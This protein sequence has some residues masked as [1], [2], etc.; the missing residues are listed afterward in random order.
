MLAWAATAAS[1]GA[2]MLTAAPVPATAATEAT[3][4]RTVT[5]SPFS[6][7]WSGG[8]TAPVTWNGNGAGGT[9]DVL[10]HGR[11]V[12]DYADPTVAGHGADCSPPPATHVI[13]TLADTVFICRNHI[14]TSVT[15]GGY[16]G[17]VLTPDHM[18]DF[19]SGTATVSFNVSTLHNDARDYFDIW[20]T[21]FQSNLMLPLTDAVDVAGPPQYALRV[22]DCFCGSNQDSFTGSVFNNF[23]E[24]PL[25]TVTGTALQSMLPPSAVTRTGFELDVSRNHVK[26]GVP[27][28]GLWWLD[29]AA[30]IPFTQG[31]VQLIHHSYDACKGQT[32]N[33]SNPCMADTWHWSNFSISQAVPFTIINGSPRSASAGTPTITFGAPAP[34]GAFL[35]FEALTGGLS[36]SFDG[37]HTFTAPNRQ[38][39]IGDH[40]V[41]HTEHFLPYFTPIPAGTQS[42][43]FTGQNWYAGVWWVRDISIW[44]ASGLS[45]IIT[46]PAAP[47]ANPPTNPA[48]NPPTNH[49]V[50]SPPGTKPGTSGSGSGEGTGGSG[51]SSGSTGST[52]EGSTKPESIIT[53]LESAINPTDDPAIALIVLGLLATTIYVV[54]RAVRGS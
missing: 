4:V 40:G 34:A 16:G 51:G 14:M 41:I 22:R 5:A 3:A 7:N 1:F 2:L 28:I 50:T 8:M 13:T 52:G 33:L 39:I 29:T 49:P 24:S 19:S 43:T 35:R 11:H 23:A 46:A 25:P 48:T 21:P 15:D 45:P 53:R 9:W 26:F 30:N 36:V 18:V 47:P 10:T 42:V 6:F 27:S 37:G 32:T 54:M 38:N 31:V 17:D 20:I 44:A 12:G